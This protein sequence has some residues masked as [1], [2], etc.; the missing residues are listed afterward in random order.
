M[1]DHTFA[2][3][4]PHFASGTPLTTAEWEDILPGYSTWYPQKFRQVL[5]FL[6]ASLV[7]HCAWIEATFPREHPIFSMRVWTSGLMGRK[8]GSVLSGCMQNGDSG[9]VATGVPPHLVLANKV[10]QVRK[11]CTV[12][13]N[14]LFTYY[15]VLFL[16]FLS[17]S[18]KMRGD[19][20]T[21]KETFL[22]KMDNQP[23]DMCD[24]ILG[25]LQV[26]GAV[27]ITAQQIT[28]MFET[29]R[30]END[31]F[32]SELLSTLETRPREERGAGP[33]TSAPTNL[34]AKN[35]T[36]ELD[37]HTFSMWTWGSRLHPVPQNWVP[38]VYNKCFVGL[39]SG[40]QEKR[41]HP[42]V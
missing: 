33:I 24:A 20:A 10:E 28:G 41:W 30:A 19:M 27:P 31:K 34:P 17:F 2:D 8:A 40:W 6:F 32:R 12:S 36:I 14:V 7:Y 39:V 25:Q 23:Q 18:I 13:L 42:A 15:S 29:F 1:N 21:F 16:L 38:H 4:P 11:A 3:L 22:L 26:N 9:L 5:P 37:G 35:T